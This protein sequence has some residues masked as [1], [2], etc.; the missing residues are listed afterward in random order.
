MVALCTLV[1]SRSPARQGPEV[2]FALTGD[3]IITRKLSVYS[4]PAFTRVIELIRGADVAVT[5]LE[6]LFHDFEPSA[7]SSSGGTYMR[8][9]A[10]LAKDL[11]WAGVDLVSRANNHTGDSGVGQRLPEA[12]EAKT[13]PITL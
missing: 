1:P 12:R 11:V 8:A 10:S 5:N 9:E 3:S 7:M 4:E 6:M 2:T 13:E